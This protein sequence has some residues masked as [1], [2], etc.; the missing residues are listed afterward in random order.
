MDVKE[1]NIVA[2]LERINA[3]IAETEGRLKYLTGAK[4]AYTGVLQFLQAPTP[5]TE[6]ELQAA[7][8]KARIEAEQADEK[9]AII[10]DAADHGTLVVDLGAPIPHGCPNTQPSLMGRIDGPHV[11]EATDK[12][13]GRNLV[14]PESRPKLGLTGI[15]STV[16][17]PSRR[18]NRNKAA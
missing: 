2:D 16:K 15:K 7:A 6:A 3:A 8:E 9:Q 13:R 14:A 11:P 12:E 5:P 10:D 4:D 17:R 1:I 18:K